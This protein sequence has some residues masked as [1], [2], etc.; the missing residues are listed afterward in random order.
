LV[1]TL[2]TKDYGVIEAQID[3]DLQLNNKY[4]EWGMYLVNVEN[5]VVWGYDVDKY[6]FKDNEIVKKSGK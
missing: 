1:K 5:G 3:S 6:E 2:L 4:T